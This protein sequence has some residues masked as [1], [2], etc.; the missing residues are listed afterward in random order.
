MVISVTS[1]PIPKSVSQ[2]DGQRF[3]QGRTERKRGGKDVSGG[4]QGPSSKARF[5]PIPREEH[6]TARAPFLGWFHALSSWGER[7]Q[8]PQPSGNTVLPS[9]P[10]V[11][12]DTWS[13]GAVGTFKHRNGWNHLIM[14]SSKWKCSLQEPIGHREAGRGT[15]GHKNKSAP[16]LGDGRLFCLQ[17][18]DRRAPASGP[19]Q[20]SGGACSDK[21][22]AGRH[23]RGDWSGAGSSGGGHLAFPRGEVRAPCRLS[24]FYQINTWVIS[25][26]TRAV[27]L[28]KVLS[29]G[30]VPGKMLGVSS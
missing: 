6:S 4:Q 27:L 13:K 28:E 29:T 7:K 9:I 24:S 5:H 11:F 10:T 18:T 14:Q 23:D 12:S 19:L 22:A 15:A 20:R 16:G 2:H 30:V 1:P 8:A 21:A 17:R 25:P 3:W 26:I